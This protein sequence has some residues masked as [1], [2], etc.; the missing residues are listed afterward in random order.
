MGQTK[1]RKGDGHVYLGRGG[2][3]EGGREGGQAWVD[4]VHGAEVAMAIVKERRGARCVLVVVVAVEVMVLL[5]LEE[6]GSLH[7]CALIMSRMSVWVNLF[8][9]SY[10]MFTVPPGRMH[11]FPTPKC[12]C[13]P[14]QAIAG[15]TAYLHPPPPPFLPL[16]IA[17]NAA[18]CVFIPPRLPAASGGRSRS[19]SSIIRSNSGRNTR[20]LPL[21]PSSSLPFLLPGIR[22]A[23]PPAA[24][25]LL[26]L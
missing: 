19:S 7:V 23:P 1:E 11:S 15:R 2:G 20:V 10:A 8:S 5:P 3:R 21:P 14:F 4:N 12:A 16:P 24:G 18:A 26:I 9:M 6:K 17:N 22:A 25:M 13:R